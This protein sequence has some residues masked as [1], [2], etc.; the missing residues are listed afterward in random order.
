MNTGRERGGCAQKCK[1]KRKRNRK[2]CISVI[3][4]N[5]PTRYESVGCDEGNFSS[6]EEFPKGLNPAQ[7]Y[8]NVA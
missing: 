1:C 4:S 7:D 2:R 3:S 6:P 5:A 8:E